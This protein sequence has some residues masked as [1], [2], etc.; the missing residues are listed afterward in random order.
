MNIVHLFYS[1][2]DAC[3]AAMPAA[4]DLL[5]MRLAVKVLR[6]A[7]VEGTSA[8][9]ASQAQLVVSMKHASGCLPNH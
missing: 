1:L 3:D 9:A 8:S 6:Q 2:C 5:A 4:A 7:A